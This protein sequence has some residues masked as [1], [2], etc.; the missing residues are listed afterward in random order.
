MLIMNQRIQQNEICLHIG[1]GLRAVEG[2]KNID[3]SP[4]LRLSKVPLVGRSICQLLGAPDWPKSAQCGDILKGLDI[5]NNSCDLVYAAHV[6]EH[7][8]YKDFFQA[9]DNVYQYLKPAGILRIIVPDLEVYIQRYLENRS[10]S[11]QEDQAAFDFM[12]HSFVGHQ[13]SRSRFDHRIKEIF[14]NYRHQWMWDIP[15]L[16]KAFSNQGLTQVRQC[17]YGDWLD[18]R[19]ALVEVEEVHIGS[20][21]IEGIK[22]N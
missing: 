19:F 20:I 4:S 17:K 12:Y 21:C 22:P 7:L 16:K 1:C 11:Q 5:P 14:S 15:S 8:S 9:L 6:F 3:S 10:D 18:P 13:G 2:W